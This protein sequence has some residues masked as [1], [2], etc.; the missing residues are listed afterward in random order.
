MAAG[1]ARF[2]GPEILLKPGQVLGL[3]MI[4]HELYTNAV[5]YGALCTDEGRIDLDWTCAGEKIELVWAET[6]YP[7]ADETP[8]SGFGQ[9][10]IAMSVKSDLNGTDRARLAAR[11]SDRDATLPARFLKVGKRLV[12]LA[13]A[14][15]QF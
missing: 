6:G 12:C 15:E 13:P 8:G 7:C 11:R 2:G 14:G 10:M 3:S 5:K 1:R 9:R 4:L